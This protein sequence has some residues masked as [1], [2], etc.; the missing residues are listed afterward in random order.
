MKERASALYEKIRNVVSDDE[1]FQAY[2]K[3]GL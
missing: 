2:V 3:G 1:L